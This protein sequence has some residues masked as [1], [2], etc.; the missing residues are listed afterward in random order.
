MKPREADAK[1][2][3]LNKIQQLKDFR[4]IEASYGAGSP[5]NNAVDSTGDD[6]DYGP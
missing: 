3:R 2:Y 1:H 5:N 6:G 4:N